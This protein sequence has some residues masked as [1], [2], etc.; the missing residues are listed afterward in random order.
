MGVRRRRKG[1]RL[2]RVRRYERQPKAARFSL[3]HIT[4]PYTTHLLARLDVLDG[5]GDKDVARLT[6]HVRVG[7]VRVVVDEV[8]QREEDAARD[9]LVV[10]E[11]ERVGRHL[12]LCRARRWGARE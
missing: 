3:S 8:Q 5:P 9:T 2:G 4:P 6:P 7:R 11:Q 10:R 1:A 12:F